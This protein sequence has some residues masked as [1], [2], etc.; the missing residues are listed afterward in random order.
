MGNYWEEETG[1]GRV[2]QQRPQKQISSN[3][4]KQVPGGCDP[5]DLLHCNCQG[6][7][8]RAVVSNLAGLNS[9]V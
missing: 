5:S 8:M 3:K 9:I 1:A 2:T 4:Y 6:H 7:I